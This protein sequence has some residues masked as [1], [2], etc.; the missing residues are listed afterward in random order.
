M[1]NDADNKVPEMLAYGYHS[2]YPD[3]IH[4]QEAQ[5]DINSVSL[6]EWERELLGLTAPLVSENID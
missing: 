4:V 6:F 1:L 2:T 3:Y 5:S